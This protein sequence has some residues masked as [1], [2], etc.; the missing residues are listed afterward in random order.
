MMSVR[1]LPLLASLLILLVL[2]V[3]QARGEAVQLIGLRQNLFV[4]L[5]GGLPARWESCAGPCAE[6]GPG[7]LL[8]R[9]SAATR[10]P[11]GASTIWS[12]RRCPW[13]LPRVPR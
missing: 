4:N 7:V 2:S 6:A 1:R 3:P 8:L 12:T 10:A 11:P 5:N 13:R 9:A